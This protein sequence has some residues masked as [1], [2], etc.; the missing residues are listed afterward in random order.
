MASR[1]K[2]AADLGQWQEMAADF[3]D[4]H[5]KLVNVYVRLCQT[6]GVG[7]QRVEQ[8]RRALRQL[9][10]AKARLDTI[11]ISQAGEEAGRLFYGPDWVSLA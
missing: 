8:M 6:A 7:V 9:Q 1:V 3:R 11:A 4:A 5:K 2:Q 10:R